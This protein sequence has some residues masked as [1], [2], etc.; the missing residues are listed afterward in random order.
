VFAKHLIHATHTPKGLNIQYDT[1][2]GPYREY[3]IAAKLE[4]DD[5]PE[6]I[7]WGYFPEINFPSGHI[8]EERKSFCYVWGSRIR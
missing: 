3:G 6:G 5:Y 2:L 4:N 1:T 7:F 8:K